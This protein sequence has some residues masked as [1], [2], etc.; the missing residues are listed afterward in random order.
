MP[1]LVLLVLALAPVFFWLWIF[2]RKDV[3]RP[4]PRRLLN[5]TFALG[6]A[7]TIPMTFV[8]VVFL[9]ESSLSDEVT[10]RALAVACSSWS[11]LRR[12]LGSSL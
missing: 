6:A 1:I 9:S 5:T 3:H 2:V 7:V 4:E 8:E 11:D 10:V 12:S